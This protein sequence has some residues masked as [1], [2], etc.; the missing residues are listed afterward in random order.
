ME[1]CV[2]LVVIPS[3]NGWGPGSAQR[4][5]EVVPDLIPTGNGLGPG[6]AQPVGEV[7]LDLSPTGNGLGPG[8]AQPVGEV[9][10]NSMTVH[11]RSRPK[12]WIGSVVPFSMKIP[13]L[14][15]EKLGIISGKPQ[16]LI[17]PVSRG[18]YKT[19]QEPP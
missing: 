19:C 7:V 4:V 13:S 9:V 16:P 11:G 12:P 5:G 6:F 14:T 2:V 10:S 3:G 8:F 1:R 17:L 18:G 15:R